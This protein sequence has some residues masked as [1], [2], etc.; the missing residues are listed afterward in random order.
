[1][2]LSV[3]YVQARLDAIDLHTTWEK[4]PK[5]TK[6]A[7][8]L[9]RKDEKPSS[10]EYLNCLIQFGID[11]DD[12]NKK[13]VE[14]EQQRSG[15]K[16]RAPS[17][18]VSKRPSKRA[19]PADRTRAASS[20]P[21]ERRAPPSDKVSKKPSERPT[22][23]DLTH[24]VSS[25]P[26]SVTNTKKSST[27]EDLQDEATRR[28]EDLKN[29]ELL[30]KALEERD[31]ALKDLEEL[32]QDVIWAAKE[33]EKLPPTVVLDPRVKQLE[34]QNE[35]LRA[36]CDATLEGLENLSRE[37]ETLLADNPRVK[38]L[39]QENARLRQQRDFT[40]KLSSLYYF[41]TQYFR[42]ILGATI[43]ENGLA[44]VKMPPPLPRSGDQ[45]ADANQFFADT[46]VYARERGFAV[47]PQGRAF[48]V[49]RAPSSNEG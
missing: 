15:A 25:P 29:E 8:E 32:R 42:F 4:V 36:E 24:A 47:V 23:A 6:D 39:E 45:K 43:H 10:D 49:V 3:L 22:P 35:D 38:E 27:L 37:H 14:L 16:R 13:F 7:L 12:E 34:E 28:L 19:V 9:L 5:K 30:A 17:D 21:V 1:M 44:H 18:E 31:D 20:P 33:L 48:T 26:G 11:W 2:A 40:A 46:K 41:G